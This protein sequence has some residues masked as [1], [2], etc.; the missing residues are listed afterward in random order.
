MKQRPTYKL[1]KEQNKA[2][3]TLLRELRVVKSQRDY[4]R[5][6]LEQTRQPSIDAKT[7]AEEL[8]YP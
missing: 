7:K 3:Q 5:Q 8:L 6:Q 4:Y 1:L 2:K